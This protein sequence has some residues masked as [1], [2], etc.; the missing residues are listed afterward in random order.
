MQVLCILYQKYI[1]IVEVRN[2]WSRSDNLLEN[3][4]MEAW[5]SIQL[6]IK[7]TCL[8][9]CQLICVRYYSGLQHPLSNSLKIISCMSHIKSN[10]AW[11]LSWNIHQR[12]HSLAC[13]WFLLTSRDPAWKNKKNVLFYSMSFLIWSVFVD[14]WLIVIH[15]TML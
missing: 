2:I 5:R 4:E 11:Q 1:Q 13:K 9:V 15:L 10:L 7:S 12:A 8:G 14:M 6:H 3:K